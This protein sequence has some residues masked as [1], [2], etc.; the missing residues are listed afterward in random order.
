M[1]NSLSSADGRICDH[2]VENITAVLDLVPNLNVAN[3]MA[4]A[5]AAQTIRSAIASIDLEALR[6]N[7]G[8]RRELAGVAKKLLVQFG[9]FGQRKLAV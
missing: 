3:D 7:M 1:V 2:M 5:Q 8:Q 9:Q 6:E 4:L